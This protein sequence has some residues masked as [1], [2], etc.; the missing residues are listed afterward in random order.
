MRCDVCPRGCTLEEGKI[1]FCRARKNESGRSVSV[2]YGKLASIA[3]DP[4]EKKPLARF[5]PGSRI[6]SVGTFG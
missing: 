5:H 3:L 1:G 4:I 2:N 6:L